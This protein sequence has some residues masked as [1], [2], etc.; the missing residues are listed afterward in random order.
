MSGRTFAVGDVHGELGH[1]E[2]LLSRLPA[3]DRGDTLVFLGDYVDR[4]PDSAGGVALVRGLPARTPAKVVALRGSHEDAWL[5][6]RR[7]GWPEFVVPLSNGCLATLRSFTGGPVPDPEETPT[8][9]E[10]TAL[11]S[12][13]FF[14]DDV[15]AW[16][17]SLPLYHEDDHAMY[18]HAGLP[19]VGDRWARP[20]ELTDPGPLMWQ[21]TPEFFG[22]YEGKRVVFG[23]TVT[24]ALPQE[25]SVYTPGDAADLF[26]RGSLVGIDTRCGHGGFLTAIGLPGLEV[27]ESRMVLGPGAPPAAGSRG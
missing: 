15:I 27:Y 2:R 19:R 23:H 7:E 26:F 18:V 20:S 9:E 24:M 6:V 21:R 8:R 5:K 17:Q 3:L 16:M 22:E 14:P 12:G 13:S 1:L 4:G 25:T 10:Y 11:F